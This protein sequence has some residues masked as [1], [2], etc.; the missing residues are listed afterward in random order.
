[1]GKVASE[2]FFCI[3]TE[4]ISLFRWISFINC[5][6]NIW[7]VYNPPG[8]I[9]IRLVRRF[10]LRAPSDPN[11]TAKSNKVL[12]GETSPSTDTNSISVQVHVECMIRS[13]VHPTARLRYWRTSRGNEKSMWIFPKVPRKC[14]SR[15][16]YCCSYHE[17][18]Q[19]GRVNFCFK[20]SWAAIIEASHRMESPIKVTILILRPTSW[21]TSFCSIWLL[22]DAWWSFQGRI[23]I[24]RNS[25][26]EMHS[27]SAKTRS[28]LSRI[29]KS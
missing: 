5:S 29:K 8:Y 15:T 17:S 18:H 16:A 22:R 21:S 25:I 28:S 26:N 14:L 2:N 10:Q 19:I 13:L 6:L 20:W 9:Y 23:H 7:N 4:K 3:N 24:M 27:L 1:M 12:R 11:L